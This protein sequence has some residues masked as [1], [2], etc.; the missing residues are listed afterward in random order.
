[1]KILITGGTGLVGKRLQKELVDRGHTL[2]LATRNPSKYHETNSIK[3]FGW[4]SSKEDFPEAQLDGVDVI[5]NLMGE[6]IADKRWSEEQKA[7]LRSSR[8]EGTQKIA[9]ALTNKNHHLKSFIS[10]SAIGIY[11]INLEMTLDESSPK[12]EGFLSDL[13]QKW[14]EAASSITY[15]RRNVVF[16]IGVVLDAKGGALGKM[17]PIF[18]LGLGGP[19]GFGKQ[20]MSWIHV[21]DLVNI[22][23][24]AVED[25]NYQGVY[26]ATAPSPVSNKVFTK[27][28]AQ[29][30]SRPAIFIAPPMMLKLAMGEMSTIVLDSQNVIPKRL[31]EMN[32]K[33]KHT[34]IFEALKSVVNQ[35]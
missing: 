24:N 5:I 15:S 32:Y 17:L 26:N 20:M 27:A 7:K 19:V 33:F 25:E 8:V 2:L 31:K 4:N 3:F 11:P 6:S 21:D 1:M 16:R 22:I 13:C 30:L 29:A 12:G 35:A 18:K 10:A 14:E 28:L 23:S 34:D 9:K